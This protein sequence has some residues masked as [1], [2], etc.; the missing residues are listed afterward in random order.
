MLSQPVFSS[1]R[2]GEML[3]DDTTSVTFGENKKSNCKMNK[4]D[5]TSQYPNGT[6]LI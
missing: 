4:N 3:L 2:E 6:N 5:L 1:T